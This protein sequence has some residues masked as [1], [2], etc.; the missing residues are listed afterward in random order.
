M[1][2]LRDISVVWATL[3]ILASFLIFF[4][5]RLSVK[6]TA[7]LMLCFM[8]PVTAFQV[9]YLLCVGPAKMAQNIFLTMA[10]PCVAFYFPLAKYRDGR[11]FYS[12]FLA[13]DVNAAITVV[14]YLLDY[15]LPGD[16]YAV[17][18]VSRLIAFPL[19]EW[20]AYKWL[21]GPYLAVQR[22]VKKGWFAFAATAAMFYL[23]LI[24]Q[25]SYPTMISERPQYIPL[26]LLTV[27]LIPCI[28]GCIF[29]ALF[30]QQELYESRDR[31][32]LLRMQ[33]ESL[34][35]RVEQTARSE[36]RIAIARHDLR[37]RFQVLDGLLKQGDTAEAERYLAAGI[38]ELAKAETKRWCRNPILNAMFSAYFG[39]AEAEGVRVE[40]ELDIPTELSVDETE[41]S[42][43]FA[44]ALENAVY[45]VRALPEERRVIRCKC[46]RFP[47]LMFRISNPY[48]GE[49]RFD[50]DGL[51]VSPVEGHGL[52]T[53]SI[54]AYCEKHGAMCA[55]SAEG[56]WFTVQITQP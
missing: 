39:M 51:P 12:F 47:R 45:A 52:G 34:R 7:L 5:Y 18:L 56:G 8:L 30:R 33:T 24:G 41:L 20:A 50:S 35:S 44:N 38:G 55:Y 32:Q 40:A 48:A 19:V 16:C 27:V 17:M 11:F 37:H 13:C 42:T 54:A 29:F 49:V 14:T 2:L 9:W 22:G 4:E 26:L 28:N 43:V 23:L 36:E 46:I 25:F 3:N 21:R 53:R 15:Y 1:T 10:L 6:K 31:E